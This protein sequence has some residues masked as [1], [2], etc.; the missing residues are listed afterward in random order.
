MKKSRGTLE[1]T[2]LI[3]AG[4]EVKEESKEKK[5]GRLLEAVDSLRL[6][7]NKDRNLSPE[8]SRKWILA[9]T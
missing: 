6:T 9:M 7:S 4:F 2:Q 5:C 1:R 8:T 3:V